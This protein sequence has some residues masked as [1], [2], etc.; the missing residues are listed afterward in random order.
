MMAKTMRALDLYYWQKHVLIDTYVQR[1]ATGHVHSEFLKKPIEAWVQNR[2]LVVGGFW[3]VISFSISDLEHTQTA[4][5]T[6][7]D[8]AVLDQTYSGVYPA[9]AE[10]SAVANCL[11]GS[12]IAIDKLLE[13]LKKEA[14]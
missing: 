9:H 12:S 8:I 11:A 7:H 3:G 6:R 4:L 2:W 14:E 13:E 5:W 1:L 10:Y